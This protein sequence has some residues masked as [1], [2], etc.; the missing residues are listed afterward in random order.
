MQI[1]SEFLHKVANRQ[2]DRQTYRQTDRQT[3]RQTE[4]RRLHN[5]GGSN[6]NYVVPLRRNFDDTIMAPPMVYCGYTPKQIEL[7]FVC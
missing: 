5:L 6:N 3:D 4:Q 1:R 2:T 7:V